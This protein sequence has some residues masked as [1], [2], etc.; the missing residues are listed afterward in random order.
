MSLPDDFKL[1][2]FLASLDEH[3]DL[4]GM[5]VVYF[6]GAEIVELREGPPY[7]AVGQRAIVLRDSIEESALKSSTAAQARDGKLLFELLG[8]GLSCS[9]AVLGWVVVAG[10]AGAAPI[11]GGASTLLTYLSI[12]AASASSVQCVNALGR[13]GAEAFVPEKV[14]VLDQQGWY[15]KTSMVL[16]AISMAGAVASTAVTI[17]MAL[18]LQASTGR[19]ML[20]VLKGLS[21]QQRAALAEEAIRIENPG[22]SGQQVKTLIRAGLYPKRLTT[23][24]INH[25]I[26]IQLRDALGA[27]LSFTGSATSGLVRQYVVDRYILGMAQSVETYQ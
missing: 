9:A 16:D 19:S 13:V 7:C 17:R 15:Q 18:K 8:A 22:I 14:D 21:R 23:F 26:R 24:Q 27:A 12:G 11:T 10:S 5:R 20:Q 3:P 1:D 2:A 6:D 4:R 25:A